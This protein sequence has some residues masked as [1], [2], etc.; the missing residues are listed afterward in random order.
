MPQHR[1]VRVYP[2]DCTNF[3]TQRRIQPEP[4]CIHRIVDHRIPVVLDHGF[5][6]LPFSCKI[7]TGEIVC[8]ILQQ[9][10]NGEHLDDVILQVFES[11][12]VGV[13]H[14]DGHFCL[15]G[16]FRPFHQGVG[17]PGVEVH[18][19]IGMAGQEVLHGFP[20]DLVVVFSEGMIIREYLSAHGFDLRLQVRIVAGEGCQKI[21]LHL[22]AV[23]VPVHVHQKAFLTTI[24][25]GF[26]EDLQHPD[27]CTFSTRGSKDRP[28]RDPDQMMPRRSSLWSGALISTRAE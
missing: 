15:C 26:P 14:P 3:L 24:G 25:H 4:V 10:G 23:H 11:P 1:S 13:H 18:D 5:R 21:Q 28:S 19:G 7:R 9:P 20:E 8:G 12:A 6:E 16:Q 17:T 22:C 27:H 2:Q